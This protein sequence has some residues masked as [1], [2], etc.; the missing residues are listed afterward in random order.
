MF[1]S[2]C[3][4]CP[5]VIAWAVNRGAPYLQPP[6]SLRP[7]ATRWETLHPPSSVRSPPISSRFTSGLTSNPSDVF[8][9]KREFTNVQEAVNFATP[10]GGGVAP[11]PHPF[12]HAYSRRHVTSST[13]LDLGGRSE[14]TDVHEE[15][16]RDPRGDSTVRCGSDASQLPPCAR[17][18]DAS[19]APGRG[20]RGAK[21]P[22]GGKQA[23]GVGREEAAGVVVAVAEGEVEPK[24]QE[25]R[26]WVPS[27]WPPSHG[28][29][30]CTCW[31]R[32]R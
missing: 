7:L 8:P 21:G 10:G 29:N 16:T 15:L 6:W 27:R 17:H 12:V 11:C 1:A 26:G 22:S 31:K 30:T 13:S 4:P 19:L 23:V 18:S 14:F 32:I 2:T 20:T 25:E 3:L 9:T 28:R 24:D 5:H